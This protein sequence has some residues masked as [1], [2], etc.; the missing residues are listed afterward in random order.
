MIDGS[1]DSSGSHVPAF[2]ELGGHESKQ[3]GD[4]KDLVSQLYTQMHL[5]EWH[6]SREQELQQSID[7]LNHELA[8]YEQVCPTSLY[9]THILGI[10]SLCIIM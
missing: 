9:D 2:A 7:A 4:I 10:H 6:A 8:P 5:S 1:T 3:L